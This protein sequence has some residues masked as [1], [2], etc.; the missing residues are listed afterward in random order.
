MRNTFAFP[1]KAGSEPDC[2]HKVH[3]PLGGCNGV[4]GPFGPL[5]ESTGPALLAGGRA[6]P[7]LRP[8]SRATASP[9]RDTPAATNTPATA[10]SSG[11]SLR[12]DPRGRRKDS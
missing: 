7:P 12:G 1:P 3:P 8:A 6:P 2:E 5:G 11:V 10:T 9:A 4:G